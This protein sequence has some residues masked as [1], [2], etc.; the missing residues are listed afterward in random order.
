M[1]HQDFQQ[2]SCSHL[3][4]FIWCVSAEPVDQVSM[5]KVQIMEPIFQ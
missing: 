4:C 2:S 1:H 5:R 3:L